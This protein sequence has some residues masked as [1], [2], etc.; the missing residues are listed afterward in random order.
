MRLNYFF[1]SSVKRLWP[2][3]LIGYVWSS[4]NKYMVGKKFCHGVPQPFSIEYIINFIP[5]E[6]PWKME[7]T[8]EKK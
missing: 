2:K 3:G 4:L 6:S 7:F 5:K 1:L 8:D